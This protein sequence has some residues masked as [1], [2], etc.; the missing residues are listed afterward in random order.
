MELNDWVI[1]ITALGG[2]EGVK[3]LVKWV[4]SRKYEQRKEDASA[5]AAENENERKQVDWLEARLAQRDVKVDTLYS[6]VRKLENEKLELVYKLHEKELQ[7][8]EAEMR[9]CEVRGCDKR[10]PPSDY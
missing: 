6:E 8:K 10:Q 3:Q 7:L 9:K 1:L 2:I 5:D 4:L